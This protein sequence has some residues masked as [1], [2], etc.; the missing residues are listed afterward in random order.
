MGA[1]RALGRW[2]W[3]LLRQEWREQLLILGLITVSIAMASVL[4]TAIFHAE[5]PPST[6]TGDASYRI[7][8]FG[9]E[10]ETLNDKLARAQVAFPRAEVTRSI[11]ASRDG[12]GQDFLIEAPPSASALGAEPIRM[13]EGRRP[14][15]E[16][17]IAVSTSL[18]VKLRIPIGSTP[19]LNGQSLTVVGLMEDPSAINREFAIVHPAHFL[20]AFPSARTSDFSGSDHAF[21]PD[22]QFATLL[23]SASPSEVNSYLENSDRPGFADYSNVEGLTFA[24]SARRVAVLAVF[25]LAT[26]V[27]VEIALLCSAGFVVLGQR[28]IR[29]S[30][31]LSAVGATPRHLRQAMRLN[32]L[33]LGFVGG[34]LG[35]GLGFGLSLAGRPLFERLLTQRIQ[36]WSVPWI[37]LLPPVWLASTTGLLAAWLPA[38]G[39][40]RIPIVD[41][42][43]SRQPIGRSTA[44]WGLVGGLAFIG[45]AA[46]LSVAIGSNATMLAVVGLVAAIAGLLLLTPALTK[47][48]GRLAPRLPLAP[49]IALRD[50][51]RHPNR[52]AAALAALVVALGIP[53]GVILTSTS[54]D[55]NLDN[56]GPNLPDNWALI[57]PTITMHGGH[58]LAD[59]GDH[60]GELEAIQAVLPLAVLTEIQL[61]K[62]PE[63]LGSSARMPDL[64]STVT[65]THCQSDGDGFGCRAGPRDTAWVATP[66]LMIALG[67]EPDLASKPVLLLSSRDEA[68]NIGFLQNGDE[69]PMTP[70]VADLS[71]YRAVPNYFVPEASMVDQGYEP[72]LAGWLLTNPSTITAEQSKQLFA[73]VSGGSSSDFT[74]VI[75]QSGIARDESLLA[76]EVQQPDQNDDDI[77]RNVLIVGVLVS[78][79]IIAAMV[80]LLRVDSARDDRALAAI[81]APSGTRRKI[82]AS[83]TAF[84]G[85]GGS[86][87]ALPGGYLALVAIT[88]DRAGGYPYVFPAAQLAIL[89]IGAPLLA[90]LVAAI[91]VRRQPASLA[92]N[93]R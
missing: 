23:V 34:S 76:V 42:L 44:R 45:G 61:A 24:D 22:P 69:L 59:L 87:L 27:M 41:A 74:Q 28:R 25:L 71:P 70:D 5:Q 83:T 56:A 91:L 64:F 80:S 1:K 85:L 40:S 2:G 3:R 68:V 52:T 36:T 78:L 8:V 63:A 13:I 67:L 62:I 47:A 73:A 81:G 92:A 7:S 33:V 19:I 66:N 18:A 55:A 46:T 90:T 32:G 93:I 14:Q 86:L 79:T 75:G 60:T 15:S 50:L 77:R 29:Q 88:S 53:V 17:E 48:A 30:G 57:M 35:V 82:V 10:T 4:A 12:A 51:A 21:L 84:L 11:I 54:S 43:A 31:L 26:I 16:G 39:V 72:V 49:R 65:A 6:F 20:G 58:G 89:L 38:R 9:D 37:I